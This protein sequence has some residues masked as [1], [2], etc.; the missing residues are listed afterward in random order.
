MAGSWGY[1]VT[2]RT[3]PLRWW[4]TGETPARWLG[5]AGSVPV[6]QLAVRATAAGPVWG[7]RVDVDGHSPSGTA[8][9]LDAA[10]ERADAEWMARGGAA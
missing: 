9:T 1:A 6:A 8:D 5:H 4:R 7:W 10:R 2:A 3:T